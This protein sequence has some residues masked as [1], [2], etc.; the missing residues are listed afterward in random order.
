MPM[1]Q[2]SGY[3]MIFSYLKNG[4]LLI[5]AF[6]VIS[7]GTSPDYERT[8]RYDPLSSNFSPEK[9]VGEQDSVSYQN[10]LIT[11]R[12][13]AVEYADGYEIRKSSSSNNEGI[14]VSD[15]SSESLSY[16]DVSGFFAPVTS[17]DV[18]SYSLKEGSKNYSDH[19]LRVDL[20]MVMF[21]K[22]SFLVAYKT[23][24]EVRISGRYIGDKSELGSKLLE[25]GDIYFSDN[26]YDPEFELLESFQSNV[27]YDQRNSAYKFYM[28]LSG[29]P[30][31]VYHYQYK[32]VLTGAEVEGQ[33]L[34][35]DS[36]TVGFKIDDQFETAS[37]R[38][39]DEL[40]GILDLKADPQATSYNVRVY[41][42]VFTISS[43]D[44]IPYEFRIPLKNHNL[45]P[46]IEVRPTRH[47]N[48]GTYHT[49]E[50]PEDDLPRVFGLSWTRTDN[51]AKLSWEVFDADK[52]RGMRIYRY[53]T[54]NTEPVSR[55]LSPG[56]RSY[57]DTTVVPGNQYSYRIRTLRSN[58]RGI[59][60]DY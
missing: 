5:L 31:E 4:G 34:R 48:V 20:N 52:A 26:S 21:E 41:D 56:A 12:W 37:I 46:R 25:N 10:G 14:I 19:S 7:C 17:Y 43:N 2:Q 32:I 23:V 29:L 42:S 54:E 35:L 57:V 18:Y 44:Q 33:K 39:K 59:T 28:I 36:A 13:E 11:L 15:V 16:T 51:G 24:G 6:V 40:T 53:A 55:T 47:Q 22:F 50:F 38:L 8:N 60:V 27:T 49:L 1:L 58:S 45:Q 9:P 30:Q 3:A